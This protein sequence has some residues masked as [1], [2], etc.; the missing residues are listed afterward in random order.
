MTPAT[1]H[2]VMRSLRVNYHAPDKTA[3]LHDCLLPLARAAR[4]RPG[5]HATWVQSHWRFGPHV[6]FYVHGEPATVDQLLTEVRYA[7]THLLRGAPS[8]QPVTDEEWGAASV[9]LGRLELVEPPYVPVRED[10]TTELVDG[11]PVDTFLRTT[12]AVEVKG[13]VLG[14]GL[15]CLLDDDGRP[16]QGRAA[17]DAAFRGMAALASSYPTWGLVSGYQAFLSHWK[18][19]LYWVDEDARLSSPLMQA[20]QAQSASL[21]ALVQLTHERRRG[22]ST[23]DPVLDRWFAWIDAE[24]PDA[25]ALAATGD[26]LPYPHASRL[27]RAATFGDATRI[28][29]SGSDEREYSDFHTA[30]R[31]LDFSKLGNGTDFAAYR[32][33]INT[34]FELLPL[35]GITPMQRYSLAFMFTESAQVV[36]GERWEETIAKAVARQQVADPEASP[37]LPWRGEHV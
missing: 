1:T 7:V 2:T 9:E 22:A 31:Q 35:M 16:L 37:T 27:E 21:N 13:R 29:W 14:A 8:G 12:R 24:L 26:V 30:F 34:F 3:L 33:I 36:V 11:E 25:E 17:T 23:G 19:Y 5:V 6:S 10:N 4:G 32:F 15:D 18:E 28:Q 20:W